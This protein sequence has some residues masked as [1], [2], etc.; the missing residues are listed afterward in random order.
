MPL[1]ATISPEGGSNENGLY[2]ADRNRSLERVR[3]EAD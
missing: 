3:F 2:T 1:V